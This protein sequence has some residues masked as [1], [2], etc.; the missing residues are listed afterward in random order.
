MEQTLGQG[1]GYFTCHETTVESGDDDGE[2]VDGPNAQHC[3]G[4]LIMLEKMGTPTQL[5]RIF[6]RFNRDGKGYA[7]HRLDMDAPVYRN[8]AAMRKAMRRKP[9]KVTT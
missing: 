1:Q 4:A 8:W 7:S 5:M 9:S 2:M 3:A 6:E